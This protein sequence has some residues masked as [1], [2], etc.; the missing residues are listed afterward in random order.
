[1]KFHL[2][3]ESSNI[4]TGPIP[5]TTSSSE[6]CSSKCPLKNF[7]CYAS[8]GNLSLH[9][10]KVSRGDRGDNFEVFV[11]KL[12]ELP[13]NQLVRLN[14]AGDL[15]GK[16]DRINGKMLDKV[17]KAGKDKKF[18]TYTHKGVIGKSY[19][20]RQNR[21]HISSSNKNGVT[22][23]LSGNNLTHADKLKKL[24][25]APVVCIIPIGSPNTLYT[26]AGHK[27]VKCPAQYRDTNCK[28]CQLCQ[29]VNRNVIVGFES[30]G[31][32]KNKVNLIANS[33]NT[34]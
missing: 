24:N 2:V 27:V 11:K 5:V 8:F 34:Y 16:N 15:A 12:S 14:Q 18:F 17:V 23:N 6:T 29:K 30:H 22:I 21:K 31:I 32:Q 26:P 1:M 3:L 28:S 10:K 7:S 33:S 9:W 13:F 19:V 20:A 4:K 25:I